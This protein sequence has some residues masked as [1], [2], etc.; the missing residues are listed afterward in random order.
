MTQVFE[1]NDRKG[2]ARP[3]VKRLQAGAAENRDGPTADGGGG[4]QGS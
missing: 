1:S 3:E 2:W 4:F